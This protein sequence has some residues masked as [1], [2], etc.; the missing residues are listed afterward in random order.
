MFPII[1]HLV[2]IAANLLFH[3]VKY[4]V[5]KTPRY[6]WF[7]EAFAVNHICF[8]LNLFHSTILFYYEACLLVLLCRYN[9]NA[10]AFNVLCFILSGLV[11]LTSI[12]IIDWYCSTSQPAYLLDLDPTTTSC[13]FGG[14]FGADP[15]PPAIPVSVQEE[16]IPVP[17]DDDDDDAGLSPK[18]VGCII[19]LV[20][21]C[22]IGHS[23]M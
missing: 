6:R 11:L 23:G 18:V 12:E 14:E 15:Q 22:V 13:Y 4:V 17:D 2:V 21:L 8:M 5:P 20:V 16:Q 1:Y 9:L 7:W 10:I 3:S 19:F